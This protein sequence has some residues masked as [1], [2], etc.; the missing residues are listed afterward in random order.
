MPPGSVARHEL[1]I[2]GDGLPFGG[3]T[4]E[5]HASE[6]AADVRVGERHAFAPAEAR[7]RTRGVRAD[8]RQSVES[9]GVPRQAGWDGASD[10]M[11][12]V[13]DFLVHASKA[14]AGWRRRHSSP[15]TTSCAAAA[16]SAQMDR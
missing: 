12:A 16:A 1:A 4:T 10:P 3:D 15:V 7:H 6:D 11:H 2:D 8:P 9:D 5:D 13:D 14:A